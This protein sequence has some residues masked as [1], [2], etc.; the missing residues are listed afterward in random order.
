MGKDSFWVSDITALGSMEEYENLTQNELAIRQANIT[1]YFVALAINYSENVKKDTEFLLKQVREYLN[2]GNYSD[3]NDTRKINEIKL[4]RKLVETDSLCGTVLDRLVAFTI[5]Q[6]NIEHV[7]SEELLI[8]LNKWKN[9]INNLMT[10]EGIPVIKPHGIHQVFSEICERL[11]T[12]GDAI[13]SEIWDD[14]VELDGDYYKLPYK[15]RV[16]DTLSIEIDD[17]EFLKNGNE[18]IYLSVDSRSKFGPKLGKNSKGI[19]LF[20]DDKEPFTTHMKLRAKSFSKWGTSYFRRAFGPISTKKRIEAL[21][22]NTIEGLINRLTIIKAGK[23]DAETETGIIAPHRLA[24]LER[25][26]MSPKVNNLLLW[27]G[28]DIDIVDIGP[29]EELVTYEK[30]YSETNEQILSS[31]GFPRVLIDGEESSTE[32]WQKFLGLIAF[33]SGVRVSYLVPWITQVM[34]KIAIK[35]GFEDEYPGF[36]F[37]RMK[38]YNLKELL[39]A[40]KIFYD[41]G[42]MSELSAVT[43]ADLD[44][45]IELSRRSVEK[46]DGMISQ[47]G[48][49]EF[50]PFSKNTP[51][52]S[53]KN[54]STNPSKVS[55][56]SGQKSTASVN[57]PDREDL[58]ITFNEFLYALHDNIS[59]KLVSAL[60]NR[61]YDQVESIF[62]T[63]G[64]LFKSNIK[65]QMRSL[66]YFEV[67][68]EKVDE[69]LL[70]SAVEWI[71][72][73]SDNLI[74]DMH[75]EVDSIIATNKEHRATLIPDLVGGIM[76]A[77]KTKRIRLYSSPI[78]NKSVIAGE[79]TKA[80]KDGVKAYRWKSALSEKTCSYCAEM[81]NKTLSINDF[82]ATYPP[83]PSCECWGESS[84]EDDIESPLDKSAKNWGLPE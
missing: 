5:T 70:N 7:K 54:N 80:K 68:G 29:K 56:P 42:L 32:N 12:D 66:F 78:Y 79:L 33:L 25:L 14:A 69:S 84:N 81:H 62:S 10:N 37:S 23:I 20:S 11:F 24:V 15:I 43:N 48:G 2:V 83:H 4:A 52:G 38:L 73:F 17:D 50:L 49:P 47:F 6:G 34:R 76:A 13:V 58:I 53:V 74:D 22:V 59:K 28:D 40:V 31:L 41:R 8:L 45:D 1:S 55:G 16:H 64:F 61:S 30:K 63:Y 65:S 26:I 21:E 82:F 39:D 27:P 75:R 67:S 51:D 36:S 19:P 9:N 72:S 44:Y 35:N 71:D 77:F 57:S 3:T 18:K 46:K 60:K